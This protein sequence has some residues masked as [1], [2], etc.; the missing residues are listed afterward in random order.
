MSFFDELSLTV[1]LPAVTLKSLIC[2]IL[3]VPLSYVQTLWMSKSS[4]N[5]KHAVNLVIG[6]LYLFFVYGELGWVHMFVSSTVSYLA[7][8]M[9]PSSVHPYVVFVWAVGYLSSMHIYRMMTQWLVWEM[10]LTGPQMLLTIKLTSFA[11]NVRDGEYEDSQLNKEWAINKVKKLPSVLE[12]YSFVFHY[13]TMMAG[14]TPEIQQY[15]NFVNTDILKSIPSTLAPG[16]KKFMHGIFCVVVHLTL[17]SQFPSS[18][19]YT[20][21]YT[22][23]PLIVRYIYSALAFMGVRFQYY[24][25][26]ALGESANTLSGFTYNGKDKNGEDRW[27]L[28]ENVKLYDVELAQN[29]Y[30]FAAFWNMS[31]AKWL[32]NHVYLR[33]AEPGKPLPSWGV[34]F[35]QGISAFWHGFYPGYY[36]HFF[37]TSLSVIVGR[38]VRKK[39]KP[40]FTPTKDGKELSNHPRRIIYNVLSWIMVQFQL[41]YAMGAFCGLSWEN[42]ITY[43]NN[44]YWSGHLVFLI[45]YIGLKYIP[46]PKV[47]K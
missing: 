5:M 33:L 29:P 14:P 17:T 2:I 30:T 42:S 4:A 41:G 23:Y 24:F 12:Y 40:Y 36:F 7:V 20:V 6:L 16:L 39:I 25:G 38:T 1:G 35:T 15:I 32:R 11:W 28:I 47:K 27:D 34:Y 8:K 13:A 43:Y 18:F 26:W 37:L 3:S 44:L 21:E 45:L 10:D 19:I 22:T 46:T 9:L 31:T